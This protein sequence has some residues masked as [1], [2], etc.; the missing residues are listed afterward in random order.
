MKPLS[1]KFLSAAALVL[2]ALGVASAAH[3]RS[4]V[5]FSVGVQSPGVYVQPAPAY[6]QPRP[7]YVAPSPAYVESRPVYVTPRVEYRYDDEWRNRHGSRHWQERRHARRYGPYG[8]LDRDG[9]MNQYDRDR[10]GD[11]A[12]NRYDRFPDNP[13]RY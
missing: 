13:Y 10:D 8:D 7:V 5:Y 12:R 11:G 4:D 1:I 6:V 3:A 9:V 2:G